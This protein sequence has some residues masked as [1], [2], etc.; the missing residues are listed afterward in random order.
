GIGP[1]DYDR[2]VETFSGGWKMRIELSKILALNP[3]VLLMDEPTNHL[4]L[5]SI[6]WLEE[7]LVKFKGALVMTSHDRDFMNR[8]V[9]RIVEFAAPPRSGNEV[10]KMVKLGKVYPMPDG[11]SKS[12]FGGA[13]AVVKRL[14]KVAVVGVNGAGKSTLLRIIAGHTEPSDGHSSL[15][16]NVKV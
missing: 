7:W 3:D 4:D 15:G 13:S 8:I 11:A 2:P 1:V 9:S 16:A 10:V 12:V 14:D 5:E 6:V